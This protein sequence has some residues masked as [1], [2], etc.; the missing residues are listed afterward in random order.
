MLQIAYKTAYSWHLA[1]LGNLNK[2]QKK[3]ALTTYY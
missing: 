2:T 1:R 3:K